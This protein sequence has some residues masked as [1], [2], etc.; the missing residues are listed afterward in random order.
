MGAGNRHQAREGRQGQVIRD[1]DVMPESS[2]NFKDTI[3]SF[4]Q[5]GNRFDS[6]FLDY[7][8]TANLI[9]Y[10]QHFK[11]SV[12]FFLAINSPWCQP[13]PDCSVAFCRTLYHLILPLSLLGLQFQ[14]QCSTPLLT[15]NNGC[16]LTSIPLK[17]RLLEQATD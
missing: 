17:L 3:K 1:L 2:L 5:K 10:Y 16:C 8:N 4:K 9:I 7:I 13:S 6:H 14:T 15:R 12:L 11:I